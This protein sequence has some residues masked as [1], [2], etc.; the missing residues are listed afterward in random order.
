MAIYDLEDSGT[1]VT[2]L[3]FQFDELMETRALPQIKGEYRGRKWVWERVPS[4][5]DIAVE[6]FET[7][8][9]DET[10]L[11]NWQK[12]CRD[13]SF[14]VIPPSITQCKKVCRTSTSKGSCRDLTYEK[15]LRKVFVNI[16]TFLSQVEAG[17]PEPPIDRFEDF[18]G[19][20]RWSKKKNKFFPLDKAKEEGA[21]RGLLQ[22]IRRR[23]RRRDYDTDE[24]A[25]DLDGL[26]I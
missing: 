4:R 15:A 2:M 8:M 6:R 24:L 3:W 9:G 7:Y 12:L 14:E 18:E 11:E 17:R 13:L 25:D 1:N 21:L 19:L 22:P 26:N 23:R 20:K 5:A 10:K 16:Y